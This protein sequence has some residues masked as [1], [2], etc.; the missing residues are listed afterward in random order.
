MRSWWLRYFHEYSSFFRKNKISVLLFNISRKFLKNSQEKNKIYYS[1]LLLT[2]YQK[3]ICLKHSSVSSCLMNSWLYDT[4]QPIRVGDTWSPLK[5]DQI[6]SKPFFRHPLKSIFPT[7][8]VKHDKD[9][10]ILNQP[11]RSQLAGFP[12][13]VV[14][15]N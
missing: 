5:F 9:S 10:D 7:V 12:Q 11:M 6:I 8:T 2:S 4:L 13:T 15:S 14:I 1:R 3:S